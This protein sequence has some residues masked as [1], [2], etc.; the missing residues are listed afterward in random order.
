MA[1]REKRY[2]DALA[3]FDRALALQP[4]APLALFERGTAKLLAKRPD[5]ARLDLEAARDRASND[6]L[7]TQIDFELAKARDALG[8]KEGARAAW[9]AVQATRPS[10]AAGEHLIDKSPCDADI[11]KRRL[12]ATRFSGWLALWNG[13]GADY[14]RDHDDAIAV[15]PATSDDEAKRA[16]CLHGCDGDGP[17]VVAFGADEKVLSLALPEKNGLG[18]FVRVGRA[19]G[20]ACPSE[21]A[22][23]VDASS[24]PAHLHVRSDPLERLWVHE[25]TIHEHVECD[26][27]L[28]GCNAECSSHGW[29][30][31]DWSIDLPS[32][33]RV[34]AVERV[35]RV[36]GT[37]RQ[38]RAQLAAKN[39][40][41]YLLGDGCDEKIALPR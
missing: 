40:T 23:T 9:T 24:S 32:A 18:A 3:A 4:R 14:A 28:A 33:T 41:V 29:A 36:F 27:S 1:M 12:A 8:D 25:N 39:G 11:D 5:E 16:L 19:R 31:R 6:G 17:W 26:S 30:E 7:A 10:T 37:N 15:R 35:G 38:P 2:D 22:I 21:D 20:G 34:L 13:L